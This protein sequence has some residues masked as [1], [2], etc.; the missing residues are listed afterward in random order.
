MGVS[1][2][3]GPMD[4]KRD[5]VMLLAWDLWGHVVMATLLTIPAGWGVAHLLPRSRERSNHPEPARTAYADVFMVIGSAPWIYD[6]PPGDPSTPGRAVG[7]LPF[8]DL[9]RL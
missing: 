5:T 8:H 2:T 9:F 6:P 7:L 1:G 4:A 3:T